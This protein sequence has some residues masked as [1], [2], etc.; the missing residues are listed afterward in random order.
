[1]T[2]RI[3]RFA[4]AAP[5][6]AHSGYDSAEGLSRRELD[7]DQALNELCVAWAAWCR[8]R[9]FYGPPPLKGSL[10]GKLVSNNRSKPSDG[11]DAPSNAE[12]AALHLAIIAQPAAGL[13]RQVF[14][15]HYL[16]NVRNI[17][18]A[19]AVLGISRQHW[20]RL[21][22]GFRRRVH[23]ASQEILNANLMALQSLPHRL[24]PPSGAAPVPPKT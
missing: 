2:G 18:S 11:P 6:R 15:L 20:Y 13:D 8:T 14:E 9:R 21:L 16:W 7:A 19:S 17:K 5:Q 10:L 12:V 4:A 24:L 1:M 22:R 23:H 3:Q